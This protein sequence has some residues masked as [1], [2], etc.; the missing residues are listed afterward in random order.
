MYFRTQYVEKQIIVIYPCLHDERS[1]KVAA[2]ALLK[3]ENLIRS[4]CSN[5]KQPIRWVSSDFV[6]DNKEEID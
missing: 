4:P 1:S 2:F 3:Q 6:E 5:L